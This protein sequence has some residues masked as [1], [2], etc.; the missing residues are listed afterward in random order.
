MYDPK[1][2]QEAMQ[3]MLHGD[4]DLRARAIQALGEAAYA[5]AVP[6][7]AKLVRESDPG[8]RYLAASALGRI[9]DE[10]ESAVP[11]LLLALR[12]DDIF[13][14]AAVTGAL[15][16][17]GYPAVPGLIRALFDQKAAVRRASAKALGKI[18]NRRA[19]NAL[20][21]AINDAD[22]GV[23]QFAQEALNRLAEHGKDD[24]T[25]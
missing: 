1:Q 2:V 12:A 17:I 4:P 16:K 10:A 13:L 9:G 19:V 25:A 8:T 23:R 24:T 6:H 15:I 21:V 20:K 7:L 11:D 14:R 18:G 5:P 3:A 22:A